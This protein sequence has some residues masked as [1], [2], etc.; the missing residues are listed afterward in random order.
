MEQHKILTARLTK[1]LLI[2][3]K[4]KHLEFEVNEL[5]SFDFVA[6]QFVSVR[7]PKAD[8][9]F[10]TRAYSIASP[11]RSDRT[12]DLCLNRVENGFMSNWLCD[13]EVGATVHFHGPH[14]HFVMHPERRDTIFIATGTGVAPF[15]SMV[16]WLF[17]EPE[18]N[19]GHD[20]WLV[21]GTRYEEDIYYRE[22]FVEYAKKHPNF[23]YEMLLSRPP[24]G[25][26]IR[27]GYVQER[28]R[29]IATGRPVESI[30]C[31]I[32]GLND[33]VSANRALLKDELGWDKKHVV[34]ERYD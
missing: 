16:Q 24:E 18:R 10:V 25:S 3:E 17:R 13:Q 6:G 29:E 7:E 31:Y 1:S 9:K 20:F 33:M 21:Y 12:F 14:G 28:V 22:E 15:R 11:P 8:G 34:F 26:P 4:T 32:C 27:K 5:E 19:Q 2:S 23:H 30:E